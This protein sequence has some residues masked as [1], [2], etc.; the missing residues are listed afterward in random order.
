MTLRVAALLPVL[1]ALAGCGLSRSPYVPVRYY[2][3]D[4]PPLPRAAA[5]TS[6]VTLGVRALLSTSAYRDR[7]LYRTGG[8]AV[9]YHEDDRWVEPPAEMVTRA[10]ERALQAA[11]VARLVADDR[12]LRRAQ[13]V[14]EGRLT[15]F[16]EVHGAPQWT[17]ECE[18]ELALRQAEGD[19][20]V[21]VTRLAARQPAKEK[22]TL[23]FVEA[24][25]VAV[26][27]IAAA[28]AE[29]VANALAKPP[30]APAGEKKS[31]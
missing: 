7:I 21:L 30:S 3:I 24:M 10:L 6:E 31:P 22:T 13:F 11:G 2:S 23:A 26:G 5:R 18:I 27:E 28:A 8:R 15:R 17:A 20:T 25:N 29:T 4:P 9:D 19:Q 14:L 1:A 16:D 12:L